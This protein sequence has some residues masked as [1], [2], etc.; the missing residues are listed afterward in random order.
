MATPREHVRALYREYDELI[1]QAQEAELYPDPSPEMVACTSIP[2]IDF[3]QIVRM[4]N[5][6]AP[7]LAGWARNH[8]KLGPSD[9]WFL[10]TDLIRIDGAGQWAW[11]RN[12]LFRLLR[13]ADPLREDAQWSSSL[14]NRLK[15][16]PSTATL[17]GD[18][19]LSGRLWDA[20]AVDRDAP[21]PNFGSNW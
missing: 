14:S 10:S 21:D 7:L 17:K 18:A 19:E 3:W 20:P 8:P 11:S 4:P 15:P 16:E 13:P 1:R 5:Y 12:H 9:N 6:G 2:S